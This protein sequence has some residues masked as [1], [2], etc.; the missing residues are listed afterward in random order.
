MLRI[1]PVTCPSHNSLVCLPV[2]ASDSFSLFLC[3]CL[4]VSVCGGVDAWVQW[5]V[6][7]IFTAAASWEGA[8]RVEELLNDCHLVAENYRK[9]RELMLLY[10]QTFLFIPGEISL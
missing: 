1:K 3:L 6:D 2:S 4:S 8:L 9:V 5:Q 10:P 7:E